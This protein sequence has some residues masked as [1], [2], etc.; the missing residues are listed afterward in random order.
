[1]IRGVERN[2]SIYLPGDEA[3]RAG[4][5]E[6]EYAKTTEQVPRRHVDGMD[7]GD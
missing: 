7:R 2:R 1:M 6:S 3:Y 4:R 5:E